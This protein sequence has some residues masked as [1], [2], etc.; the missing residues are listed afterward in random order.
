L[1]EIKRGWYTLN[2]KPVYVPPVDD[3]IKKLAGIFTSNY[4]DV[5]YCV[6]DINWLNEFTV[7]QFNRELL[8]IE[9][10][11]DLQESLAYTLADNGYN[12][13]I[14]SLKA[15]HLSLTNSIDP[16]T[17]LPLISRAPVQYIQTGETSVSLP[18]LEKILVDIYQEEKLFYFI[19][20]AEMGRIF[21]HAFDCYSINYTSFFGYA[22]RRGK[23]VE[24]HAFMTKYF[25]EILKNIS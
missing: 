19:Q 23:E 7:H 20:G 14:W 22:K 9:T 11:K 18:I 4:R 6:W 10:E 15:T 2:V 17:I 25:P 21:E 16:I 12:N 3:K 24:L 1:R 5:R 13:V 8:L